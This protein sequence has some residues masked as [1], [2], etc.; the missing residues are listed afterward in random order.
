MRPSATS[1][2]AKSSTGRVWRPPRTSAHAAENDAARDLVAVDV[3]GPHSEAVRGAGRRLERH[4][5]REPA[6]AAEADSG[7]ADEVHARSGHVRGDA[8]RGAGARVVRELERG[9]ADDGAAVSVLAHRH[10]RLEAPRG[11]AEGRERGL[12]L[13]SVR[14]QATL[15][16]VAPIVAEREPDEHADTAVGGGRGERIA[17]EARLRLGIGAIRIVRPRFVR[18]LGQ[19]DRD[20]RPAEPLVEAGLEALQVR[21]PDAR[22]GRAVERPGA[23]AA[24]IRMMRPGVE[25]QARPQPAEAR[26][27]AGGRMA[28]LDPVAARPVAPAGRRLAGRDE[29]ARARGLDPRAGGAE[30]LVVEPGRDRAAPPIELRREELLQ[31]R[32]VPHGVEADEGVARMAARVAVCEG[33]RE[34][35]QV[36][37]V[38]RN[39]VAPRAAV[40][41]IWGAPDGQE[42]LD[43]DALRAADELVDALE[44]QRGVERVAGTPRRPGRYLGP[45][46]GRADHGRARG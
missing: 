45:L 27:E 2:A 40:G 19:P 20:R 30:E 44:A 31:V 15:P 7:M 23:G 22:P 9:H 10:A 28:V 35:L 42:H 14:E 13:R 46:D 16:G 11:G 3:S 24:R 32:L 43:A 4:T 34:R 33:A 29:R 36:A 26:G 21:H 39:A 5:E 8:D 12:G 6:V 17:G 1:S 25:A 38:V 41:P 18:V 37:E